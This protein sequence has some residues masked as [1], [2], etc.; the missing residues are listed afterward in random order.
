MP[1]PVLPLQSVVPAS[2]HAINGHVLV[3]E[4][5]PGAVRA[6]TTIVGSAGFVAVPCSRASEALDYCRSGRPLAAVLDI[7]LPDLNGLIHAQKLREQF[8]SETPII[9]VSGDTSM[10]TIKSLPHVGA[11]CFLAK[12][13]NANLLIKRLRELTGEGMKAD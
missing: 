3:V 6:M 10:E 5:E 9:L 1:V 8:G 11:T 7:H 2:P 13:L 4:D 12:P